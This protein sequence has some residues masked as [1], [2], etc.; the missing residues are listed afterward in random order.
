MKII[1]V[2]ESGRR[3]GEDH[4]RAKYTDNEIAQ[5]HTL[6]LAGLSVR[7]IAAKMDIPYNTVRDVLRGRRRC[8]PPA[9]WRVIRT[10]GAGD[11]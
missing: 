1:K 3:C 10:K 6:R 8:T 2:S 4:Q 9:S 5:L 11:E 7:A